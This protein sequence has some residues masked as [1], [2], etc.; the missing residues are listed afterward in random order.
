MPV[1][2]IRVPKSPDSALTN[3][4]PL[5]GTDVDRAI[6]AELEKAGYQLINPPRRS[7][8]IAQALEV[9]RANKGV[10]ALAA[11]GT[12]NG[13]MYFKNVRQEQSIVAAKRLVA[14]SRKMKKQA[15]R[16]GETEMDETPEAAAAATTSA[17][18]PSPAVEDDEDEL[19]KL[20]ARMG[21]QRRRPTRKSRK[22]RHRRTRRRST[23]A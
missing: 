11:P 8:R 23:R 17:V 14:E 18:E 1:E 7:S 9:A 10:G 12:M 15:K 21:G 6:V 22:T 3:S 19:A 20:F 4:G 13:W 16:E 5:P 2:I